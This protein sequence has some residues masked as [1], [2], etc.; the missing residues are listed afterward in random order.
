MAKQHSDTRCVR[1][2][3]V[4]TDR[5]WPAG[6]RRA[7]AGS[8]PEHLVSDKFSVGCGRSAGE[9]HARERETVGY[10]AVQGNIVMVHSVGFPAEIYVE[11]SSKQRET[12]T[13]MCNTDLLGCMPGSARCGSSDGA[14][15]QDVN[16]R[17]RDFYFG[18]QCC[19]SLP[20]SCQWRLRG[21]AEP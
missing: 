7:V 3:M 8:Y 10:H 12:A 13:T 1:A 14:Y 6:Q 20:G 17:V 9:Q 18:G 4:L 19:R 2:A 21:R 11:K 16:L 5:D 15:E